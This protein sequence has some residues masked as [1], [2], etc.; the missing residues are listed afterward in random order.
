MYLNTT[1][2][3]IL[4]QQISLFD[5]VINLAKWVELQSDSGQVLF[6]T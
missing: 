4:K 5:I 2:N 6:L 1:E 3:L